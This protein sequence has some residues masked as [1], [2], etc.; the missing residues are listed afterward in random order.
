[1]NEK[2]PRTEYLYG[3]TK[4]V[5]TKLEFTVDTRTGEISLGLD[6]I[7][8]YSEM[9]YDRPKGPKVLSRV[10]Q[11]PG[12]LTFSTDDALARN[13]DFLYA[14]DTNTRRVHW[15]TIS[16]AGIVTVTH[17]YVPGPSGLRTYW[18]FEIPF[19]LV[20]TE[21]RGRPE[22]MGW[23]ACYESLR[24]SGQLKGEVRVGLIVDS[25]LGNINAFN[26]RKK[27]IVGEHYLPHDTQLIYATS[28]AGKESVV[29]KALA[30]ADSIAAQTFRAIEK[31]TPPIRFG[32]K[33]GW[34]GGFD[35]V[36]PRSITRV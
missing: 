33:N 18:S 13:Y 32:H 15:Q 35:L 10:P 14:I 8:T 7:N 4:D 21:P 1:V 20:F 27:P 31:A 36:F 29:N 28:D 19:V 2:K 5:V 16:V 26:E 30:T 25:D 11:P 22:H 23:I 3:V 12:F 9:S 34:F 17:S 6:V 24:R